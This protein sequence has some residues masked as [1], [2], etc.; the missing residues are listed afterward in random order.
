VT[1]LLLAAASLSDPVYL[2]LHSLYFDTHIK[3]QLL[4]FA[5]TA[6]LFSDK[7]VSAIVVAN[8]LYLLTRDIHNRLTTLS[9][10]AIGAYPLL[11]LHCL[12]CFA[13][14]PLFFVA[15]CCC[16]GHLAPARPR[17]A[18]LLRKS[19]RFAFQIGS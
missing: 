15:W 6:M 9:Y 19:W 10:R 4:Q 14:E 16:M 7:K 2:L 5:S 12:T 13:D 8:F 17:F 3:E 18:K 1:G 11:Y